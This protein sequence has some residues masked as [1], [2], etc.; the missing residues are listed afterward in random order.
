MS[1]KPRQSRHRIPRLELKSDPIT[2]EYQAEV[3]RS[4]AKLEAR[5]RKAQKALEVAEARAERARAQAE[6]L[7]RKQAEAEAVA[8]NRLANE[9]RLGE[10]IAR[11]KE[12]A[13]NARV[14]E[15][16]A[17]LE[18]Q[19]AEAVAKRNAETARRREEAK[20][21]RERQALIAKSRAAITSLESEVAERRRELREI[22]LLMMPGHYAGRDH[23]KHTAQ[24]TAGGR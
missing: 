1:K 5:Y 13:K 15:A 7:A 19:Q 24:H 20:A 6:A 10:F 12:A 14:A 23:R 4:V 2:P 3:D 22:E 17:A 8:A 16:R 9:Q 21:A 11:I 18:R